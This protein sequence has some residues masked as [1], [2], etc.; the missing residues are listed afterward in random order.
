[1]S[2][3]NLKA[4]SWNSKIAK[5]HLQFNTSSIILHHKLTSIQ[6]LPLSSITTKKARNIYF[7]KII[8]STIITQTANTN[9][10]KPSSF[11]TI[12]HFN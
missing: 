12:L 10:N 3:Q 4:L 7:L 8:A 6:L 5:I 2:N 9:F 1:M 11:S